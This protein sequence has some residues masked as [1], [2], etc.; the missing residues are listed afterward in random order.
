M[1]SPLPLFVAKH[2]RAIVFA[3]VFALAYLVFAGI[4]IVSWWPHARVA[5]AG[6]HTQGRVTAKEPSNHHLIR[7][8]FSVGSRQF[9]GAQMASVVAIPFE[10]I[11]V[12]DAVSV[13]YD[14]RNPSVSLPGDPHAFLHWCYSGLFIALP[15]FCALPATVAAYRVRHP[16][17]V[18]MRRA[19]I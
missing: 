4:A 15:L 2:S 11:S 1:A 17:F 9:T 5:Y 6:L 10:K 18:S 12:G 14:A 8:A 13:A 7:Y 3:L 19:A 16:N